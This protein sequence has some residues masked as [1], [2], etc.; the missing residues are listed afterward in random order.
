MTEQH[1]SPYH[2]PVLQSEVLQFLA[3]RPGENFCDLTLGGAGHA[4]SIAERI[5]PDGLLI[6]IDRDPDAIQEAAR[7]LE[8]ARQSIGVVLLRSPFGQLESAL[9]SN[10]LTRDILLDGALMDL[11]VSSHQLDTN[12]GFSFQRDE[13]ID[14][15]MDPSSGMSAADF[16][17][18]EPESE[19]ARV[20]WEYGEERFSRRL[21]AAIVRRREGGR[22]C[23]TTRELAELVQ[24]TI[25]R[26]AWPRDIHAATRTFQ[27]LRI[28][29]NDELGELTRGLESAVRRLAPGGRIAVICYHSLE[30]RLVK[31]SFQKWSGRLPQPPGQSMAALAAP[32]AEPPLLRILT[33]KPVVASAAEI[34]ANPRAR[35]AKVRAAVRIN[36]HLADD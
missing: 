29:V 31:R 2:K 14:M 20:L 32:S 36:F 1:N 18:T 7:R 23:R 9:Q 25:P 30:E 28:A 26:A 10:E 33:G 24:E 5:A 6:G 11:G 8:S 13:N 4:L 17:D 3:P 34:A 15:R 35:S 19:I 16:L 21:A 27:A 12:R 22:G